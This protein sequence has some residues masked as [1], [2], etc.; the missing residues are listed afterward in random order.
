[1]ARLRWLP[2]AGVTL[3][4]TV[5]F[6]Q[7]IPCLPSAA[8]YKKAV[9]DRAV[10]IG[11]QIYG[12]RKGFQAERSA[13]E[14]I[15]GQKP[16]PTIEMLGTQNGRAIGAI[17]DAARRT[18]VDPEMLTA[19]MAQEG[20]DTVL[21]A[22]APDQAIDG[23]SALGVDGFATDMAMLKRGGFLR[24][25]YDGIRD[26]QGMYDASG[27]V[28]PDG[29]KNKYWVNEAGHVYRAFEFKD[30]DAAAEGMAAYLK[31]KQS[32]FFKDAKNL[33]LDVKK[34]PPTLVSAWTYV[35]YNAGEGTGQK[36]LRRSAPT[37]VIHKYTNHHHHGLRNANRVMAAMTQYQNHNLFPDPAS[38][39]SCPQG[40]SGLN[41][42]R[43]STTH[44]GATAVVDE[45]EGA[46]MPR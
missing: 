17:L 9:I 21:L 15:Y 39:V 35:Y 12:D 22:L 3:A 41:A 37:G 28:N 42:S 13:L 8:V 25:D 33:G 34:M 44:G 30:L 4:A 23:F 36:L 27:K 10:A 2:A 5:A 38:L 40:S 43:N 14:K 46:G 24:Q 19:A 18:G 7:V 11:K 20:L 45:P 6:A 29:A 16:K 1:M 26:T 31:L 32:L